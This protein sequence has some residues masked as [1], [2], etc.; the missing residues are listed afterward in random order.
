M[1]KFKIEFKWAIVFVAAQLVWMYLEK[2]VGLHDERI[3]E[4]LIYTNLFGIVA[5]VV[6]VL[7]LRDKKRHF[8]KGTM[9]WKQGI[10]SGIVISAIIALLSPL[11]QYLISSYIS[12]DYFKNI[13]A[14]SVE[15]GKMTLEN[16]Q[17]YF[18]LKSYMIQSAFGALAMGVV[19]SAIVAFFL[20]SKTVSK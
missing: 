17:G 9:N 10:V 14:Y 20:K 13:I 18:S 19:T 11:T 8:F 3:A 15:N 16:A 5:I 7:A 2:A 1:K 4:Q 6:Y 12:P